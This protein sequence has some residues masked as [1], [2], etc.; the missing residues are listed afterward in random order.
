VYFHTEN[1]EDSIRTY[2][3]GTIDVGGRAMNRGGEQTE[4]PAFPPKN[5]LR[6][7][8]SSA[9]LSPPPSPPSGPRR[10]ALRDSPYAPPSPRRNRWTQFNC[11]AV[12]PTLFYRPLAE[13][14]CFPKT[15]SPSAIDKELTVLTGLRSVVHFTK[16]VDPLSLCL[17]D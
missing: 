5:C 11:S 6:K 8:V 1:Q 14:R 7:S 3:Y 13:Y 17:S 10:V 9:S 4:R 15:R 2:E 12:L 16:S